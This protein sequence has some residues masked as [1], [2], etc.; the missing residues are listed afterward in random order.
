M[1]GHRTDRECLEGRKHSEPVGCSWGPKN[2]GW[3]GDEGVSILA[4]P[5]VPRIQLQGVCELSQWLLSTM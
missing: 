3:E 4:A 2:Q 5:L 1:A